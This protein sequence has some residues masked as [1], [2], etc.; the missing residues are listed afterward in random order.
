[1][2]GNVVLNSNSVR[3]VDPILSTVTQGYKHPQRVG[4][5][6]FPRV[7]VTVSG[8]KI[9]QFG[10]ESFQ[11]FTA[12]RAPG[13]AT[14]RI[15]FGYEGLPFALVQDSLEGKV[16][17][18]WMR[19]ASQV[20]GIDLGTRAVNTVMSSLTLALENEQATIATNP[21]NYDSSH[22]LALAG[23]TKWSADTGQP[24]TN[25]ADGKEAVRASCG[26]DPNVCVLSPG[27]WKAARQN[28]S[29]VERFKFTT[30]QPITLEMFA[31]LIEVEHVVVGKAIYADDAGTFHDVWGNSCVLAYAP[32]S[33]TGQEEPS[34]GYTYTMEGNPAVE[35]PYWEN[36][37]KS[38]M[39]GVT[40][41]RAPVLSGMVAGFLI[42]N[43]A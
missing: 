39:Y 3:V 32:Q 6:L 17:R 21:A 25:V 1:M 4:G 8:G 33:P 13:G 35:V 29:V 40:Y 12:R 2:S 28:P 7:P 36:N 22:K 14:K 10:K 16:P 5:F 15:D 27:A 26:Q 20:P 19:D 30:A 18:E 24:L 41:E 43:P 9:I 31:A 11:L 42:Q 37:L 38:W 34:Y 23:A